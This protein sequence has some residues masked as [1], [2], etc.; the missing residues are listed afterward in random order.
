MLRV[1]GNAVAV[2]PAG[3]MTDSSATGTTIHTYSL[4]R[5]NGRL[6]DSLV[7]TG[8]PLT[9]AFLNEHSWDVYIV[10][11]VAVLRWM[12]SP[13][14]LDPPL[15]AAHW[16]LKS[17]LAMTA[18]MG[19]IGATLATTPSAGQWPT[20]AITAILGVYLLHSTVGTRR[21]MRVAGSRR[22]RR[23][24]RGD[25]PFGVAYHYRGLGAD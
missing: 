1:D 19:L 6:P 25:Q 15:S 2:T 22:P 20:T 9:A 11:W 5:T 10:T 12:A 21:H 4:H 14:A 16:F 13:A 18:L 23:L 3:E 7:R 8:A 24:R 17:S